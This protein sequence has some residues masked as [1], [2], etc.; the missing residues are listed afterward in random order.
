M[1]K[2]RK[3]IHVHLGGVGEVGEEKRWLDYTDDPARKTLRVAKG[4]AEKKAN[5]KVI[6]IDLETS[7]FRPY[8]VPPELLKYWEQ[9]RIDFK[10]GLEELEDNSVD[11]ISSEMALGHYADESEWLKNDSL[12][13]VKVKK[14]THDTLKVA[15]RK[16]K[17]GGKII[18]TTYDDAV[19]R[20]KSTFEG[21][22]FKQ[23]LR[24][25]E[26]R[27]HEMKRTFFIETSRP[28]KV[29][30]IMVVK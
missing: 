17:K 21:T 3:I 11:V 12:E 23:E 14:Y 19:E 6:G 10:R 22:G 25:R 16:L 29:Y 5:F 30:Q 8:K 1:P 7:T 26:L 13:E 9:K 27:P 20:I 15:Y 4:A 28:H 2:R 24:I 18:I